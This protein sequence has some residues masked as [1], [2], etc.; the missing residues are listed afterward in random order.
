[1][2]RN[3]NTKDT[4]LR[5]RQFQLF[6][7]SE[8]CQEI[9]DDANKSDEHILKSNDPS[10]IQGMKASAVKVHGSRGTVCFLCGQKSKHFAMG[11]KGIKMWERL[12]LKANH[13]EQ[14]AL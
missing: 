3:S 12:H 7:T 11:S 9:Y 1:M 2:P 14:R 10:K 13:P 8:Q 6:R 5:E 4:D